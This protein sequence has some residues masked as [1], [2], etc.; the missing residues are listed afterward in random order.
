MCL[1]SVYK[2]LCF[3]SNICH[4]ACGLGGTR[5]NPWSE[6]QVCICQFICIYRIAACIC[7]GY[8]LSPEA[9]YVNIYVRSTF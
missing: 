3:V 7:D 9:L 5:P 1:S 6:S 8:V 4:F 2:T